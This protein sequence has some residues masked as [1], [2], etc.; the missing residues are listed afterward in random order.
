MRK[1]RTRLPVLPWMTLSPSCCGE[2]MLMHVSPFP[3][4]CCRPPGLILPPC[5][6][7]PTLLKVS[8]S[9]GI[10]WLV[11]EYSASLLVTSPP[12]DGPQSD[13]DEE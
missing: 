5:A 3:L 1:E 6:H 7:R 13:T 8:P 9:M 10:S 12:S 4:P 2:L 11:Y